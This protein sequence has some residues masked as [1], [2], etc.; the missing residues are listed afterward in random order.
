MTAK[1]NIKVDIKPTG[2][3]SAVCEAPFDKALEAY[4]LTQPSR[5]IELACQTMLCI[6][7][8]TARKHMDCIENTIRQANIQCR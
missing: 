7:E 6:D 8:R 3:T 4:K 1:P 2:I 5:D